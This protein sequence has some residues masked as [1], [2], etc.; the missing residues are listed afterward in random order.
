M[1]GEEQHRGFY[2]A[3]QLLAVAVHGQEAVGADERAEQA[4]LLPY[5]GRASGRPP[6]AGSSRRTRTYSSRPMAEG[7]C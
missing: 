4:G 5:T 6:S 2:P 7:I 1:G 3:I